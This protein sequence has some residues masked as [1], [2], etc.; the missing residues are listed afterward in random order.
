MPESPS[1]IRPASP[2]AV[3]PASDPSEPQS[4]ISAPSQIE[5]AKAI[6]L[7]PARDIKIEE[8]GIQTEASDVKLEARSSIKPKFETGMSA[9]S[10]PMGDHMAEVWRDSDVGAKEGRP[11]DLEGGKLSTAGIAEGPQ[12]GLEGGKF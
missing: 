12:G 11:V 4:H 8:S 3:L 5:D 1:V 7:N 6:D 9:T 2:S 10:G